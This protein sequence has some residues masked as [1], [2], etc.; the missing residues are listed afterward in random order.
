MKRP[1]FD[2]RRADEAYLRWIRDQPCAVCGAAAPSV[3]AHHAGLSGT[4]QKCADLCAVPLCDPDHDLFHDDQD[5]HGKLVRKINVLNP[6]RRVVDLRAWFTEQIAWHNRG[7][8]YMV[9]KYQE[10]KRTC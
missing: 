2:P 6:G 8:G 7:F 4:G 10:R 1:A 5:G 3:Q 9:W